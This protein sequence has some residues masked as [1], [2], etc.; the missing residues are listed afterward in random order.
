M[1]FWPVDMLSERLVVVY[2]TLLPQYMAMLLEA[3]G[4]KPASARGRDAMTPRRPRTRRAVEAMVEE[5]GGRERFKGG[6]EKSYMR[7]C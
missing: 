5:K 4:S 6:T 7:K 2:G 3:P 1:E